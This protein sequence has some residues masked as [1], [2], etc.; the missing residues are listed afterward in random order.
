MKKIITSICFA[1]LLLSAKAQPTVNIVPFATGLNI[2]ISAITHAND[3][4]LFIAGQ[5]GY[6]R[7]ADV[8]GNVNPKPFLDIHTKVTPTSVGNAGEQGLLG[9]AFS[10]NYANDGTFYV[11]YTNK[12][13]NGNTVIARYHVTSNPD[14]ADAA[15]EEI[16]MTIYQPYSNHNGG[17]LQFGADGYLYIGMGDGGDAGDPQNRAQNPDSL[18]GKMLRIDVSGPTGYAIPST[19]PFVSGGARPEIWAIG[20]RNPWRFS[21]DR[22][23]HDLWIGDVGQNAWEEVD[24]Q[25]ASSV[26]GENYGW[27]CYEGN[28]AYSTGGCSPIGSYVAPVYEYSHSATSGCSITGGYVYRG[29]NNTAM[30]DY[31]FFADYCNTKIYALPSSGTT[32]T[33]A[34]TFAGKEFTTFGENSAAELF[35]GDQA[36]GTVYRVVQTNVSVEESSGDVIQQSVYPNPNKGNFTYEFTMNRSAVAEISIVDV[37]GK[38][39]NVITKEFSKGKNMFELNQRLAPGMYVLKIKTD[40]GVAYKKFEVTL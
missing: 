6:I 34:G 29:G 35:I 4:R 26:G 10:P 18:L 37:V 30:Y 32:A 24:K 8:N 16:L 15:S 3:D 36:T 28:H 19:N 9:L 33:V 21:F 38:V 12:T 13:G 11:N 1:G 7:I 23:T 2:A 31:Y 20:V 22:V 17:C 5:T 14:S 40:A 25:P 27:R 39:N